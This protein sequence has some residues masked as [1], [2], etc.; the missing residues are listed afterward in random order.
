MKPVIL[1]LI[2]YY[3]PGYKAGGALR[4]V[5]NLVEHLESDY[6]FRILTRDRD[7]GDA[8]PY[9]GIEANRWTR[10]GP[11]EVFHA[12]PGRLNFWSVARILAETDHDLLYLNSLMVPALG[13]APLIARRLGLA[14]RRPVVIA[15]RGVFSAGAIGLKSWKKRPYLALTRAAGL[16]RGAL[17]QASSE[18][19]AADI[20]RMMGVS[21]EA[22]H[23]A[24]DL[25]PANAPAPAAAPR[26]HGGPLEVAFLS[27]ITPVKNLLYALEV[28]GTVACTVVFRIYGPVEDQAYWRRCEAAIAG[29]PD[30]VHVEAPGAIPPAA[31]PGALARH[32]LFFLPTLGENYGHVIAEALSAGVPVLISRETSWR[33]LEAEGL[34]WDLD[35]ADPSAF[36]AQIEALAAESPEERA[37]RREKILSGHRARSRVDQHLADNRAMFE[38]ALS[39]TE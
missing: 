37:A 29:L 32:D 15:P 19:E 21:P 20:R 2:G 30:H 13:V 16:Y 27:R 12:A 22:I 28:L 34:G 38:R 9:D 11:A 23:I 10:R 17:W 26:R 14:P 24:R 18:H 33:D 6:T 1:V 35:L 36:A 5:A 4:S 7:I 3:L 39:G 8:A 25:P 31:V